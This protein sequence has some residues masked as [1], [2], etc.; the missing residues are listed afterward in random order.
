M[1]KDFVGFTMAD[2][3]WKMPANDKKAIREGSP[4]KEVPKQNII[5]K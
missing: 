2:I 5:K 3:D 4:K 1:D